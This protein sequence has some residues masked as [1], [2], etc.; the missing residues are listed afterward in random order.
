MKDNK[1]QSDTTQKDL[2]YI[3]GNAW[4]LQIV[5]IH[6]VHG[7]T[8]QLCVGLKKQVTEIMLLLRTKRVATYIIVN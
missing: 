4:I 5:V 6:V 2:A 1:N 7:I 8:L 3:R